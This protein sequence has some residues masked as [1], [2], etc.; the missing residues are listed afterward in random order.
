MVASHTLLSSRLSRCS[1]DPRLPLRGIGRQTQAD[2]IIYRPA[3]SRIR[4]WDSPPRAALCQ[5]RPRHH[6]SGRARMLSKATTSPSDLRHRCHIT[7]TTPLSNTIACSMQLH[8]SDF[9]LRVLQAVPASASQ[10]LSLSCAEPA[11]LSSHARMLCT[12]ASATHAQHKR[13]LG[14]LH[15]AFASQGCKH[16]RS[17][18]GGC[19]FAVYA[20]GSTA[21]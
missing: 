7:A 19:E 6:Q 8:T 10:P 16:F 9:A 18:V 1:S 13:W 2:L 14:L 4:R 11:P 15:R 12:H 20:F 21:F 5:I 3:L 17:R